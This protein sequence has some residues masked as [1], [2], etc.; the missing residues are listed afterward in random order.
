MDHS[1]GTFEY[2]WTGVD[3]R[4]HFVDCFGCCTL[5]SEDKPLVYWDCF[6]RFHSF[7]LFLGY[8]K[9]MVREIKAEDFCRTVSNFSLEYRTTRQA[10]L[11]QRERERRR[12]GGESPTPNTPAARQKLQKPPAQVFRPVKY[13]EIITEMKLD[14]I[15]VLI[16][17]ENEEQLR[18]EEI[19]RTPENVS[20]LD[21][22]LP[23]SRRRPTDTQGQRV[24]SL[25]PIYSWFVILTEFTSFS[26]AIT[27]KLTWWPVGFHV[28]LCKICCLS[29]FMTL[30]KR[31]PLFTILLVLINDTMSICGSVTVKRKKWIV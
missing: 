5:T 16:Q 21:G 15:P 8:S 31:V 27:R 10:I 2:V 17:H 13:A 19:L 18:L 22:T 11:L 4:I 14:F 24:A 9:P 29:V 26:G 20:R 7:L 6:S 23:R 25:A 30:F 28:L 1:N 12:S 3:F